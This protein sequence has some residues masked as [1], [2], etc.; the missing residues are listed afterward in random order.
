MLHDIK[1]TED[2]LTQPRVQYG[3]TVIVGVTAT[4][5]FANPL[6]PNEYLGD[7]SGTENTNTGTPSANQ[8]ED[9]REKKVGVIELKFEY[10]VPG[11]KY[12]PDLD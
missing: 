9:I 11:L 4:F 12:Y 1:F 7:V 3:D 2:T 6:T 8:V 10:E 5:D